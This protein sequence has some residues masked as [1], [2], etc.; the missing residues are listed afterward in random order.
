MIKKTKS[1]AFLFDY[2]VENFKAAFAG[3][4][5]SDLLCGI[6]DHVA[7]VTETSVDF[8]F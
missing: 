4:L 2:L 5:T 1:T 8:H 6:K 3:A 7:A